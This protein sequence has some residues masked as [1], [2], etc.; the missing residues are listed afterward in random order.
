MERNA[1]CIHSPPRILKCSFNQRDCDIKKWANGNGNNIDD[2]TSQLQGLQ[3]VPGSHV[4]Q[5][6]HIQLGPK[7]ADHGSPGGRKL[8][9]AVQNPLLLIP[10]FP[11]HSIPIGL[12][13][14][15]YADV[16]EYLP[17]T[18]AIGFRITVHDKWTVPFVDAFGYNAPTGMLSGYGVRMV[19]WLVGKWK[20]RSDWHFPIVEK[21]RATGASVRT[22]PDR[23]PAA[24]LVHLP[25]LQLLGGGLPPELHPT[26]GV[27]PSNS[28]DANA[29]PSLQCLIRRWFASVAAP[30][31]CS[32]CRA[33]LG[34]AP[35][36][37]R[38]LAS[39]FRIPAAN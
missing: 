13:V 1:A 20:G 31:R 5:L 12:R 10:L 24:R 23:R 17:T 22:L 29:I 36:K 39:A 26:G 2:S 14:L 25:G 28:P 6:L 4:R 33:G 32:R 21:V 38:R 7:C 35:C 27:R 3:A 9:S 11:L 18:E 37:S 8:W 16:S 34:V 19:G 15:V 30:T